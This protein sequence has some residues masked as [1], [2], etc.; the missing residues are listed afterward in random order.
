MPGNQGNCFQKMVGVGTA[1][2]GH[3]DLV[4]THQQKVALEE[5]PTVDSGRRD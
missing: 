3:F 5:M 2:L 4:R 1:H